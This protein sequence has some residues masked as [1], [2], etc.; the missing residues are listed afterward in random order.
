MEGDVT[1][2]GVTTAGYSVVRMEMIVLQCEL[3]LPGTC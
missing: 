1:T 2:L 3:Q